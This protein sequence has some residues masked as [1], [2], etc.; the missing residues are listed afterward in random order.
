MAVRGAR[1]VGP[2]GAQ[3]GPAVCGAEHSGHAVGGRSSAA[4]LRPEGVEFPFHETS[5]RKGDS[6]LAQE[7]PPLGR[8]WG[9]RHKG[10]RE[11]RSAWE[12]FMTPGLPGILGLVT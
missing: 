4:V 7:P 1:V 2:P 6:G 12:L 8:A 5:P 3:P 10:D 9:S 11:D